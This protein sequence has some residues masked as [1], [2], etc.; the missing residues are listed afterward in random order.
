ME[1]KYFHKEEI[2]NTVS[3]DIIFPILLKL[4]NFNSILDVGCGIGTWLSKAKEFGVF[5]VLG[6]DGDYVNKDLLVRYLEEDEFISHDLTLP[7]VLGKKF[8]LVLCLEVAEHLPETFADVLIE[9]LV[10]HSD[11]I[12]F[13]AAIPGQGGQNHLNEQSPNYWIDKFG[14]RGFEVFD[15]VRPE[16]WGNVMVDVWY[17]QNIFLFSRNKFSFSKPTVTYMV[18]PE[19]FQIKVKKNNELEM[20]LKR[21]KDGKANSSFYFKRFFKSLIS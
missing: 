8:D 12:L 10:N 11:N 6:V 7:L 14:K 20:E 13:S 4:F 2:H 16:V 17:K 21:I 18:H 19:L 1:V 15:V 5:D 9:G 3:A